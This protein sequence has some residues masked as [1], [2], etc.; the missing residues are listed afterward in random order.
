M[1]NNTIIFIFACFF[2]VQL[3]ASEL[4][5]QLLSF[6]DRTGDFYDGTKLLA[7]KHTLRKLRQLETEFDQ[8]GHK[9]TLFKQS[10]QD[11]GY[12]VALGILTVAAIQDCWDKNIPL[13]LPGFYTL[14]N[15]Y[16]L[17]HHV[18]AYCKHDHETD[19]I[20]C[21]AAKD[22]NL[23][24]ELLDRL[25]GCSLPYSTVAFSPDFL[26]KIQQY[27]RE[28]NIQVRPKTS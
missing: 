25:K 22:S 7:N 24:P 17:V 26:E 23:S 4:S 2:S 20:V 1:K 8:C 6:E 13:F 18:R 9:P 19:K 5:K 12:V 11:A 16:C 21:A 27:R 14:L 3:G 28:H 15:S 10:L